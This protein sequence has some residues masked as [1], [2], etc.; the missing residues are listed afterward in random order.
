MEMWQLGLISVVAF[1]VILS[2]SLLVEYQMYKDGTSTVW[3]ILM[4]NPWVTGGAVV[5]SLVLAV[6][7]AW[8]VRYSYEEEQ[9]FF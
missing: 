1:A 8:G 3:E 5:L 6:A 9:S 7:V 2:L 4:A